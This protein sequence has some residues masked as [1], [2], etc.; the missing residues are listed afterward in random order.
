MTI[1]IINQ[2]G[3]TGKTTTTVNL[4]AALAKKGRK[5]M[6][7]DFDPQGN[8]GYSFG[9]HASEQQGS[10]TEVLLDGVGVKDILVQKEGVDIAPSN[11]SLS[12]AEVSLA[13]TENR[14]GVLTEALKDVNG[15]DYRL[16]DCPPS[17][18]L[19]T[20]NALKVADKVIIPMQ[21]EVLALQ[22]LFQIIQT[23]TKVKRSIN[24]KVKILG[25]LPVMVDKRRKLS[26]EVLNHVRSNYDSPIFDTQIRSNVKASEAPSFGTSVISYAPSSNS[27]ID[28]LLF[29]DEVIGLTKN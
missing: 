6:L 25:I 8:M 2:K 26:T 12:D 29:A 3:G 14:E 5:V 24:A 17:L 18:S 16:I 1:A 20:I 21:M 4:G 7:I 10:M 13:G 9:I 11:I 22:G 19:L 15:Y 27:A 28:Y 23:L